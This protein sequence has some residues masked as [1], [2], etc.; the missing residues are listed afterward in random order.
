MSESVKAAQTLVWRAGGGAT[1]KADPICDSTGRRNLTL[2]GGEKGLSLQR[3]T[4]VSRMN[5][6]IQVLIPRATYTR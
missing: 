5:Y 3:F 4:R 1:G 2:F 6:Y